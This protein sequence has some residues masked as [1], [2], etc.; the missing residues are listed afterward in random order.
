MGQW[1]HRLSDINKETREAF[2]SA[3][4][5][6][7]VSLKDGRWKCSVARKEHHGK[8]TPEAIARYQKSHPNRSH[9]KGFSHLRGKQC[10]ICGTADNLC[11]D[12]DHK[13]NKFRGTL[14]R[15]CNVG[16]GMFQDKIALLFKAVEYLEK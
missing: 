14:C 3:C 5:K 11:G 2:C 16:L 9:G 1:K 8:N 15:T 10:E 4:G 13:A 12:H 6:V 7:K